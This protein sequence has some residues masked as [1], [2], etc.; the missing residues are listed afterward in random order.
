V[1]RALLALAA[2]TGC[3]TA[4]FRPEQL[5]SETRADGTSYVS[6]A[7]SREDLVAPNWVVYEDAAL[8]PVG[9][10]CKLVSQCSYGLDCVNHTCQRKLVK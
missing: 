6:Y 1:K 2:V 3:A 9:G 7:Y 5:S 10:A 4:Q 8:V